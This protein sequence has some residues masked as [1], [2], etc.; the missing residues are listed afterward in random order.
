MRKIIFAALVVAVAF[1]GYNRVQSQNE[2]STLSDLALANVEALA[3]NE[4]ST[5]CR[6]SRVQDSSGCT[7]HNCVSNGDGNSCTCGA[8]NG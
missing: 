7:Y 4:S 3:D 5:S 6:W 8:T 1:A 2:K